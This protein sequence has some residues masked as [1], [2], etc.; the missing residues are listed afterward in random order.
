MPMLA[1]FL[2]AKDGC[3]FF[4]WIRVQGMTSISTT[5]TN[6]CVDTT[7]ESYRLL[8]SSVNSTHRVGHL[9]H[10][11][12]IVGIVIVVGVGHG[13]EFL[14]LFVGR[15]KRTKESLCAFGTQGCWCF[16][17]SW[18]FLLLLKL[19]RD[20]ISA[21]RQRFASSNFTNALSLLFTKWSKK[22]SSLD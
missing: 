13:D 6:V 2:T 14:K 16:W 8:L 20:W 4:A 17:S 15:R 1:S 7:K 12:W 18:C 10:G 19:E 9:E 21:G 5:R 11:G 3:I 22:C